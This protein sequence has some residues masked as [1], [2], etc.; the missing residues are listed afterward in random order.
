[1][2]LY[3]CGPRS[4][5]TPYTHEVRALADAKQLVELAGYEAVNPCELGKPGMKEADYQGGCLKA[6]ID[7]DGVVLVGRWELNRLARLEELVATHLGKTSQS[8]DCWRQQRV[9]QA[10][11]VTELLRVLS[12]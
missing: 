9:R 6:L 12:L 5:V 8:P 2:K 11:G 1:M 4:G 3:L 7:C 10:A